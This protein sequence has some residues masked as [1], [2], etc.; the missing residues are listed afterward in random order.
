MHFL[1]FL[2]HPKPLNSMKRVLFLD[3]NHLQTMV[4]LIN[5]PKVTIISR[6]CIYFIIEPHL[7]FDLVISF[8]VHIAIPNNSK[9]LIQFSTP[10][11]ISFFKLVIFINPPHCFL[12]Y[13]I[14]IFL[15]PQVSLFVIEVPTSL[16]FLIH[17][18]LGQIRVYQ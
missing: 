5:F 15:F 9:Q 18:I 3:S 7:K 1:R 17:T 12:K 4:F 11:F 8:L 2:Q 13:F 6:F 10:L 14:S 16:S